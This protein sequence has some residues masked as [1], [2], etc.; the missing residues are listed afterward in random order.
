MSEE[1]KKVT[2]DVSEGLEQTNE[3][4]YL[5]RWNYEEQRAHDLKKQKRK[6]AVWLSF[7]ILFARLV[8]Q[9]VHQFC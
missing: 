1:Q 3:D 6:K 8:R 7:L 5:Y 4:L 2:S 9:L